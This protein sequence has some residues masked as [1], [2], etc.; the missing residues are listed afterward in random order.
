MQD[1]IL[2]IA[3][4]VLHSVRQKEGSGNFFGGTDRLQLCIGGAEEWSKGLSVGKLKNCPCKTAHSLLLPAVYST[5]T[6]LRMQNSHQNF[7][8]FGTNHRLQKK[9]GELDL[10]TILHITSLSV[11]QSPFLP[12]NRSPV[13]LESLKEAKEMFPLGKTTAVH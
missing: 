9:K 10:Y 12:P 1:F 7:F 3:S 13:C 4:K 11:L 6:I 8:F 5:S 2:Y